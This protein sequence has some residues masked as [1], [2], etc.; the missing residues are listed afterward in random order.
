MGAY[1]DWVV[2]VNFAMKFELEL[3][4]RKED[5]EQRRTSQAGDHINEE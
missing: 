3:K 4:D 1:L 2:G 5:G